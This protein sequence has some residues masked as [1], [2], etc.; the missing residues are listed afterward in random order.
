METFKIES[1]SQLKKNVKFWQHWFHGEIPLS[2]RMPNIKCIW[3]EMTVYFSR[4][5][6]KL[7]NLL[8]QIFL[9]H[10]QQEPKIKFEEKSKINMS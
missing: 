5:M 8:I 1:S 6:L 3:K 2:L 10:Q 4:L 7:F 9:Q